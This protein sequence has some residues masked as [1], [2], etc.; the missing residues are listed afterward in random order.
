[1]NKLCKAGDIYKTTIPGTRFGQVIFYYH[2]KRYNIL[3]EAGRAGSVVYC[4]F[5][6]VRI[7]K[8]YF[9]LRPCWMLSKGRWVGMKEKI[10]F[11]GNVLKDI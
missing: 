7:S 6:S 4:Y 2:P 8:Y 10:I 1:M 5:D 11:E 3:I 9:R